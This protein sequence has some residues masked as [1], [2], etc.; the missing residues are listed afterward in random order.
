MVLLDFL[1]LLE[2]GVAVNTYK[3]PLYII[4]STLKHTPVV[5]N[6]NLFF[7]TPCLD[8]LDLLALYEKTQP[9]H[10]FQWHYIDTTRLSRQKAAKENAM[11]SGRNVAPGSDFCRNVKL[12]GKANQLMTF[13]GC[14]ILLHCV[15]NRP[16]SFWHV[17][18]LQTQGSI[19]QSSLPG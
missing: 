19:P 2:Q 8:L 12:S 3:C 15:I 14:N 9:P 7:N 6:R 1:N 18:N 10:S 16:S 13:Q 5:C 11:W 4:E 17:I